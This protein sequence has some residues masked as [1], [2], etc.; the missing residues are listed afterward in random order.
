MNCGSD[1]RIIARNRCLEL[2]VLRG[3]RDEDWSRIDQSVVEVDV[4]E[5]L[6]AIVAR[7]EAHDFDVHVEQDPLLARTELRYVYAVR[8]GSGRTLVPGAPP[9]AGV[10]D[11]GPPL[12]S[13]D[14]LREETA[15]TLPGSMQPAAWVLLEA[16]PVTPNGKLDRRR[17]PAPGGGDDRYQAPRSGIE[18]TI[19]AIWAELLG[20]ERVG[21]HDNF[22]DLGGH[23]LLLV[24]VHARLRETLQADFP[25]VELFRFPTVASLASHLAKPGAGEPTAAEPRARGADRR[26]AVRVRTHRR[27]RPER[28]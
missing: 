7:F 28:Q 22:F 4:A 9:S 20:R 10:R 23:S 6:G 14:A 12:L 5:H 15:R 19:A 21:A 8:R 2:D 26:A 17:L 1:E 11:A 25:V 16:L 24:R 18:E 13:V 3:L 27:E